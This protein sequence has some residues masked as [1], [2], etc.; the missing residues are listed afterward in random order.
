MISYKKIQR[1]KKILTRQS[2]LKAINDMANTLNPLIDRICCTPHI[3]LFTTHL[4]E[5]LYLTLVFYKI[6]L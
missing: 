2:S 1:N 6:E 5:L 4:Y 3:T